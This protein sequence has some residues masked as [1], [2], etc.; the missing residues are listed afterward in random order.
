MLN[1][2]YIHDFP[3]FVNLAISGKKKRPSHT[4][5]YANFIQMKFPLLFTILSVKQKLKEDL[6]FDA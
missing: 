1:N 4:K 6:A 5:A 3:I 2:I